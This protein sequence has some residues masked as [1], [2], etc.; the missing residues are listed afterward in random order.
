MISLEREKRIIFKP[1]VNLHVEVYLSM[2]P[3]ELEFLARIT[4]QALIILGGCKD[5]GV[6]SELSKDKLIVES[7]RKRIGQ[8][9]QTHER[10]EALTRVAAHGT[11]LPASQPSTRA[12]CQ[13]VLR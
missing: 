9:D 1:G 11:A 7:A 4:R 8:I 12:G 2:T 13:P 6:F 3:L 10:E 5:V